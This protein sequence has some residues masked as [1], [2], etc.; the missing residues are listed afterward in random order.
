MEECLSRHFSL[1]N[2][3]DEAKDELVKEVL[4]YADMDDSAMAH[5]MKILRRYDW[6]A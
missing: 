3:G 1:L 2:I 6:T 5:A 4:T